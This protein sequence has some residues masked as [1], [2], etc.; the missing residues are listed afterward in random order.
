[1][2]DSNECQLN[3]PWFPRV[4][5]PNSRGHWSEVAKAKKSYR[6]LWYFLTK[7]AFA[8]KPLPGTYAQVHLTIEFYPPTKHKQDLDNML[9]AIK[10][11]LD[12]LA[13]ALNVN[14]EQFTLTICKKPEIFGMI[15][16]TVKW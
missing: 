13:D 2:G 10:S 8:R 3:M 14:D 1:M 16:V 11:G 7:E 5:S 12:G 15:M 9:A 4:L 6:E